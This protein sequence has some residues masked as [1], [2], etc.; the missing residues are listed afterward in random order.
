MASSIHK[1]ASAKR[2]LVEHYVYLA[3]NAGMET[4]ER[5]LTNADK[6]FADL[7]K[8]P[9]MGA[10]LS[11][12]SP[13][14]AGLRKWPVREFEKMLIFYLPRTDGVSIVRVLHAAQDWWILLGI[15]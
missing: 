11:L 10:P 9:R 6:S 2:D 13:R 7:A 15:L 14:L 5:F 1:R 3:E 4:A 12:R 8:H